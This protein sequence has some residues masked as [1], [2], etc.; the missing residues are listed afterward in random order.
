MFNVQE[1]DTVCL[2]V[3]GADLRPNPI[4]GGDTCFCFVIDSIGTFLYDTIF[5]QTFFEHSLASVDTQNPNYWYQSDWPVYNWA[6]S[7]TGT[8]VPTGAYTRKT[9]GLLGG[10]LPT[11]NMP[12]VAKPTSDS[13]T[14]SGYGLR[15]YEDDAIAIHL[16]QLHGE[17]C[18]FD[19]TTAISN[20]SSL[21]ALVSF[22]PNPI[23][24]S[25]KKYDSITVQ[26]R[27]I[28]D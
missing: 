21:N 7:L 17:Q 16:A 28:V 25:F 13:M 15:C 1:G 3:F 11:S 26:Y 12:G 27:I 14:Y 8:N 6:P 19:T 24:H 2:P 18:L 23:Q 10:L 9:G 20:V 22:Y 4:A 5:L